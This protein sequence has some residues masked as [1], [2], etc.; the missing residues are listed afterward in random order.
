MQVE[1]AN[2]EELSNGAEA[3]TLQRGC[4]F[5]RC[6]GVAY[7]ETDATFLQDLFVEWCELALDG[8]EGYVYWVEHDI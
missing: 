4:E 6:D 1:I 7:M 2:I 8:E 5:V 3:F